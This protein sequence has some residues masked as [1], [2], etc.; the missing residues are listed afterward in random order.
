[1]AAA[2][3]TEQLTQLTFDKSRVYARI[4]NFEPPNSVP[5]RIDDA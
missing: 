1:M 3:K 4:E 2:A 5:K